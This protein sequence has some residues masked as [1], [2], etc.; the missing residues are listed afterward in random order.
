M[1][2]KRIKFTALALLMVGFV[3][4]FNSCKPATQPNASLEA[5]IVKVVKAFKAQD[6]ATLNQMI[7]PDKGLTVLFRRGILDEYTNIKAIDLKNPVV[8]YQ[9]FTDYTVVE[10]VSFEALPTF[11]CENLIWSKY[12]LFC[13]ENAVDSI[14][15]TAA[16][17]QIEYGGQVIPE[18][19]INAFKALEK[20]SRRVVLADAKG[21]ELV[22]YLTKMQDQWYLT[23]IDRV[24]SDC[25]A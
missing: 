17:N 12:G 3:L 8:E 20:D 4:M 23:L 15:S 19:D 11:D 1:E 21:G 10:Q 18:T 24:T 16:L 2:N 14:L 22:F 7:A 25:S 6:A 9:F 13:D 5:A